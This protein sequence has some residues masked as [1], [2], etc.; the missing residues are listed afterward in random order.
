MRKIKVMLKDE[1]TGE[2]IEGVT[3]LEQTNEFHDKYKQNSL[4]QILHIL[5]DKLNEKL[6]EN[7]KV[8]LPDGLNILPPGKKW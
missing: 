4:T 6:D 2:C 5:N 7:V 3:T 8:S 1:K